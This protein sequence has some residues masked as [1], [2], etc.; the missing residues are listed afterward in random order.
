MSGY[1]NKYVKGAWN[2]ICD[3]CGL[4]Y[5]SVQLSLNWEGYRLCSDC[6]YVRSPQETR[7]PKTDNP[8]VPWARPESGVPTNNSSDPLDGTET[9]WSDPTWQ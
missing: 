1:G 8:K 7:K 4:Q 3:D 5:K 6:F 9:G 2:V